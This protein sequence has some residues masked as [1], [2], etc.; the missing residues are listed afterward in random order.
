LQ[1]V[2]VGD[3]GVVTARIENIADR[4]QAEAAKG[5]RLY[6]P[7]AA[8]PVPPAEEYYVAD[9]IGLSAFA[10]DGAPL[11]RIKA[12]F[13]F[14]AGDIIEVSGEQG[15]LLVPF[16]K[17]AVPVVDLAGGRV[18]IDPPLPAEEDEEEGLN[19]E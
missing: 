3:K 8:L 7:R 2:V 12:V 19:R 10:V 9:L 11:G 5:V 17:A 18:T 14:G 15:D 4:S 1:S 13:D 16:T 6:E